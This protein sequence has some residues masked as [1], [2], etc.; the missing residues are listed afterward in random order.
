MRLFPKPLEVGDQEGFTEKDI[1][2]RKAFGEGM[3]RL[4]SEVE[5]PMI[6][7][8]DGQWGSGKTTFLKMWAGELRK[9]DFPVIFLDAFETDYVGD[10]FAVLAREIVALAKRHEEEVGG[11]SSEVKDK[12]TKLGKTLLRASARIATNLAVRAVSAG[13]VQVSDIEGLGEAISDTANEEVNKYIDE[14][15]SG[16]EAEAKTVQ[17]FR[18]VL[19]ELPSRI[20]G[21]EN[22]KPLIFIVDELDRCKPSYALHMIERMKH[23]FQV[24]NVRKRRLAPTFQPLS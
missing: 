13:M 4:V 23:F 17:D 21:A 9:A 24:P 1:F 19:S 11:I 20:G 15:L 7:A 2:N 18:T 8:F 10:P 22:R 6:I 12:A 3:T 16:S 5:D 14:L